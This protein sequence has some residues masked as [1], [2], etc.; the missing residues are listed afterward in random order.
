[1]RQ[2]FYILTVVFLGAT[3]LSLTNPATAF[4]DVWKLSYNDSVIFLAHSPR[5]DSTVVLN[6]KKLKYTDSIKY[7]YK[8]CFS[9]YNISYLTKLYLVT[10]E[11]KNILV[12]TQNS[13]G[14]WFGNFSVKTVVHIADSCNC[15]TLHLQES[16]TASWT[17]EKSGKNYSD[18]S[19]VRTMLNIKV[20]R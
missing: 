6:C 4:V 14:H 1:M 13:K 17:D 2:F 15:N 16:L 12:A 19:R 7:S 9:N 18:T 10:P 3:V 11:R 5:P 20:I 8:P